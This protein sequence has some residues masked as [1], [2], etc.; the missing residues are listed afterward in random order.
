MQTES[1]EAMVI[2]LIIVSKCRL[3]IVFPPYDV[4]CDQS[5]AHMECCG[6]FGVLGVYG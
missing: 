3:G 5:G 6:M 1:S 4:D 2:K